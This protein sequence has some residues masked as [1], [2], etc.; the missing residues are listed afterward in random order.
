MANAKE[1]IEKIWWIIPPVVVV[2]GIPLFHIF[3]GTVV[4]GYPYASADRYTYI[5]VYYWLYN[6]LDSWQSY[7]DI[8][9][10][11]YVYW[12]SYK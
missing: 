2:L 7:R 9:V 12:L 5:Y 8:N 6:L 1:I 11:M 3:Y 10:C 4:S